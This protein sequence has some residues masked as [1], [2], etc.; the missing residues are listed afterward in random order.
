M[1][2]LFFSIVS[3]LVSSSHGTFVKEDRCFFGE[4][5]AIIVESVCTTFS[6]E[7]SQ[8]GSLR[9]SADNPITDVEKNKNRCISDEKFHGLG[10]QRQSYGKNG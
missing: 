6:S 10:T 2:T 9:H 8:S 5:G 3:F 7:V 4:E 1:N